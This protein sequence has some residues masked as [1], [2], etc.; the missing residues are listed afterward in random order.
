MGIQNNQSHLPISSISISTSNNSTPSDIHVKPDDS[1]Y[2]LTSNSSIPSIFTSRES[3]DNETQLI[4]NPVIVTP[5]QQ[6]LYKQ[7]S[8]DAE[9]ILWQGTPIR[10]KRI[11][12]Y[13][14]EK[15]EAGSGTELYTPS[16]IQ[17][18]RGSIG[19]SKLMTDE[20]SDDSITMMEYER[21]T[22]ETRI[23]DDK[24]NPSN[25]NETLIDDSLSVGWLIITISILFWYFTSM[26]RSHYPNESSHS[27]LTHLSISM[28]W[29][30]F[31][32][33]IRQLLLSINGFLITFILLILFL[34][35][36]FILQ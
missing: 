35:H 7:I 5:Q 24:I 33:I 23:G 10:N 32:L 30:P 26:V 2:G 20:A 16:L 22:S 6:T 3:F 15:V 17:P 29:F 27:S 8:N 13:R 28:A 31:F 25:R 19:K 12:D 14:R 4:N 36:L 11:G 18:H 21:N 9:C 1:E 34:S